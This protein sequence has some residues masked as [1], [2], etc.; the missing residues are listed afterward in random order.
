M[1]GWKFISKLEI[2]DRQ[3]HSSP[4]GMEVINTYYVE[5]ASAGCVV[6]S[7]LLG[8]VLYEGGVSTTTG[9][10][11]TPTDASGIPRNPTKGH[12]ILPAQ[13]SQY[14]NCYCVDAFETMIH[15]MQTVGT[16]SL[17]GTSK[18][19]V[20]DEW[21]TIRS[22][23]S[24][25]VVLNGPQSLN[26]DVDSPFIKNSTSPTQGPR[27]GVY[28]R[29]VFRPLITNYKIGNAADDGYPPYDA[30]GFPF[31]YMNLRI[32]PMSRIIPASAALYGVANAGMG[33]GIAAQGAAEQVDSWLQIAIRRVMCPNIPV[34]TLAMLKNKI[35]GEAYI[36]A[37]FEV[38][39]LE[40]PIPKVDIDPGDR[41]K[42]TVTSL[43]TVA[44]Q[45]PK[46]TLRFDDAI[47]EKKV[48][49]SCI[50][51]DRSTIDD[52]GVHIVILEADGVPYTRPMTWYDGELTFS[53]RTVMDNWY[54]VGFTPGTT[55][56]PGGVH[57]DDDKVPEYGWVTW[58][59]D[60]ISGGL[61]INPIALADF[62]TFTTVAGLQI[63]HFHPE[64]LLNAII[65]YPTG[66]YELSSWQGMSMPGDKIPYAG[67]I[68]P[69]LKNLYLQKKYWDDDDTRLR[70]GNTRVYKGIGDMLP[71]LEK[72][73]LKNNTMPFDLLFRIDAP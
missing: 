18:I 62:I 14:L 16:A 2:H 70:G 1:P 72:G 59:C 38:P 28:I 15:P 7:A 29:A 30:I 65:R 32:N 43:T 41:T 66:W 49:Q 46:Q 61:S 3:I 48:I 17:L 52:N 24:A 67:N 53:W 68:I 25:T 20:D 27:P 45:F 47:W 69:G 35:N 6:T 73:T 63:P 71:L 4:D 36:P 11:Q 44:Q 19:G 55:G 56:A 58:N 40:L 51:Q 50:D 34:Q 31:D 21:E 22:M 5:P 12:R 13:D 23:L 54:S 39:G 33:F 26:T 60:W 42:T 57:T 64:K 37:C 10:P 9:N 8:A